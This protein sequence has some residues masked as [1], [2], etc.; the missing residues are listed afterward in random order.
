MA[1][2]RA[3]GYAVVILPVQT[4]FAAARAMAEYLDILRQTGEP[5]SADD[6]LMGFGDFNALF[7]VP[8]LLEREQR[9]RSA[10]EASKPVRST[11]EP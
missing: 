11:P 1:R 3:L 6:R 7:E 8:R 2:L 9:F 5:P 10:S 4:L